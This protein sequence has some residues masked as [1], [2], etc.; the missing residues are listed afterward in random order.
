M[1]NDSQEEIIL[2]GMGAAPGIAIGQAFLQNHVDFE[3]VE[4]V[5]LPMSEVQAEVSRFKQAV[6]EAE[7]ELGRLIKRSPKELGQ[8]VYILEAHKAL[9]KDKM[10]YGRTIETIR[11][12]RVNAEWALKTTV[13]RLKQIFKKIEDAYIRERVTDVVHVYQ[14]VMGNLAGTGE[15]IS[16][17]EGPRMILVAHDISPAEASRVQHEWVQAFV[18]DKGGRTSHTAI[19]ARALQMPAVMGLENVTQ[20]IRTGDFIIVDGD[21]GVVVINPAEETLLRYQKMKDRF[22]TRQAVLARDA[23]LPATTPDGFTVTVNANI[24]LLEEVVSVLD[25][26]GDGVG[27]YRTEFLYMNRQ[28]LPG[29]DEL[30]GDYKQV[31]ELLAPRPVTIRTLDINGD[32]VAEGICAEDGDNPALG[33][34]AVRFC[35]ANP[36]IF[37]TQ[38]KAVFRAAVHG[39]VRLLFPMISQREELLQVRRIMDEAAA[40]LAAK[41]KPHRFDLEVGVMI[42]VPSAALVCDLLADQ[43]DFF[44]IGTNDLIQYTMAADRTN[45]HVAYLFQALNPAIL[46]LLH[47]VA[48]VGREKNVRLAMCGEMAGDP[49]HTPLLLGMGFSELSMNSASVPVVKNAIRRLPRAECE[50]FVEKALAQDSADKV[51]ALIQENFRERIFGPAPEKPP[52]L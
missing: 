50:A 45:K 35:L 26:G 5:V 43:V 52:A 39:N 47:Q 25:W 37:K 11:R 29:E 6:K 41:G 38:L 4:Q 42:E 17:P 20:K 40:E 13:D 8:H 3:D 48:R 23:N 15:K 19:I 18:T 16:Q 31:V 27:L 34:R 22:E 10:F 21:S 14:Q 30:Y 51:A 24:E 2:T 46:R 1:T 36:D 44:S 9:L 32:K 7:K 28:E 33:L 12:G 49:L